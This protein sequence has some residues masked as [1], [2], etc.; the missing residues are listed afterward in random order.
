VYL[1]GDRSVPVYFLQNFCRQAVESGQCP[2]FFMPVDRR[3]E[4][5]VRLKNG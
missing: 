4:L 3:G 5:S 2:L 1:V